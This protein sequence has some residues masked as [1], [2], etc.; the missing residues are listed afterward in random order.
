ML[1]L[2]EVSEIL[3]AD[4]PEERQ[5]ITGV[6]WENYEA[7]LNDLGDSL[8]YRVTYLDGVIELVSPSRRHE[9][10]KT[11][12]GSLLEDYLKEKRIRYFPLGSTTFRKQ[13]KRGGVEPDESYCI[14]TEKDFPD[15]AIEV[16]VTSGGIDKLEVYK[17]LGVREVWFFQN[18]QFAVYHLHGESYELVAKSVL[19]PNLDLSILAKYVVADDPLDAALEFREKIK[20]M[21]N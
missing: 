6:N 12:I 1:L 10:R 17:R 20:E 11:V 16:V 19:L 21:V 15:L 2:Q 7:L 4:D 8:Q 13:A 5:T 14:G 3:Q 9:N 18:N